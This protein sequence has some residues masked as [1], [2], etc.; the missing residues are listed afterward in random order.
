M[1]GDRGPQLEAVILSFLALCTVAVSLR[2]YTMGFIL[3]RLFLEDFLAIL[4]LLIYALFTAVAI[5]SIRYGLG[6]HLRDVTPADRPLATKYCFIAA[7]VYIALSYLVKVIVGLFLVR[8]CSA[9]HQ[10]WQ[11]I[12]IWT[13]LG[14]VGLFYGAYFFIAIFACQPVEFTWTRYSPDP[15]SYGKC[16]AS[17]AATAITYIA[18]IMNVVAD[19]MLAILPATVVWQAQLDKKTKISISIILAMGSIASVATVIRV[20]YAKE[21]LYQ[22]EYLYNFYDM[23]VWSTVECGMALTASSLATLKPL[24]RK[25]T[26]IFT[27]TRQSSFV[28]SAEYSSRKPDTRKPEGRVVDGQKSPASFS[29][30]RPRKVSIPR[31]RKGSV[32]I[33]QAARWHYRNCSDE[34]EMFPNSPASNGES[35]ASMSAL[36]LKGYHDDIV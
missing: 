34:I 9:S 27:T 11:R 21:L 3:K 2:I 1:D 10:K 35:T 13:M 32:S 25:M 20:I 5:S 29:T 16:N 33:P 30:Y 8:I 23:A 6:K 7:I 28:H 22:D 15:P 19:W 36:Y 31:G 18:T 12:A 17:V 14:I 26:I 4:A 24:F